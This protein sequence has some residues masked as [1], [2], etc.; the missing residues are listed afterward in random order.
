MFALRP[1]HEQIQVRM[2]FERMITKSE[3]NSCACKWFV[4]KTYN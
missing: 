3:T 4:K 2:I 1:T